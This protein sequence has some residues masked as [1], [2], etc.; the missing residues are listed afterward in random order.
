MGCNELGHYGIRVLANQLLGK[1]LEIE[2]GHTGTWLSDLLSLEIKIFGAAVG[3][4]SKVEIRES[5]QQA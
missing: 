4:S 2:M 5:L 1:V 3:A